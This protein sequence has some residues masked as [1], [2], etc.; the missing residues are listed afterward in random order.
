MTAM[1]CKLRPGLLLVV[2]L[3]GACGQRAQP[4]FVLR[5]PTMGTTFTVKIADMP[6]GVDEEA[7]ESAV[8]S[9][10][11]TVDAQMSTYRQDTEISRFNRSRDTEWFPV[12]VEFSRVVAEAQRISELSRG[13][14]DV[15]VAPLVDAWGF[16]P[17]GDRNEVPPP[18]A[19]E[20]V[21]DRVGYRKLEVRSAPPALRKLR[22]DLELDLNAI[23]QGFAVDLLAEKLEA[24][25]VKNY[26]VEIGGEVRA[27]GRNGRG[28][29]WRIAI[30]RPLEG[31]RSVQAIIE[32][33]GLAVATSG[34]YRHYFERDGRRY[35]HTI[36]PMTARPVGERL[37]SV[38][39]V[40]E[41]AM[42]SDALAT[43]F[44]VMGA[45]AGYDLALERGLAALF[46]TRRDG[47]FA[48]RATPAFERRRLQRG[49]GA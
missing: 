29:I 49:S 39:V 3:L 19:I 21:R 40:T 4:E 11:A 30:E 27:R 12:S 10:L 23:A 25:A 8:D 14:F 17:A 42:E 9:A 45:D 44:T 38:T 34:D 36:D 47:R 41:S 1:P 48:E 20:R 37:A 18:A 28:S 6:V 31:E 22:P 26:M 16:G 43:A 5:G 24:L 2:L 33:D 35:S 15:T 32:I 7:I 13:A 46:I